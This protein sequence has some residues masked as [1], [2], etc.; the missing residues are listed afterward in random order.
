[1]SINF[2]NI[3]LDCINFIRNQTKFVLFFVTL[4]VI[5]TLILH[6]MMQRLKVQA[7]MTQGPSISFL[8]FSMA[9]QLITLVISL[10]LLHTVIMISQHQKA[11][12]SQTLIV[13]L[14]K[15]PLFLLLNIISVIPFALAVA[16]TL[17]SGGKASILGITALFVGGYMFLRFCLAPYAYA[18]DNYKFN[19]SLQFSW[20]NANGRMFTLFL[21]VLITF[22]TPSLI[23]FKL[24]QWNSGLIS[25]IIF[26]SVN[27]FINV[28]VLI[29]TYR[30]YQLFIDRNRLRTNSL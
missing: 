17:A 5:D 10:W 23:S 14:K 27:G 1:M 4:L 19:Q 2:A 3:T 20:A 28:F 11:D 22:I 13:S 8:L 18:I 21:F 26:A 16:S 9:G 12:L 24:S 30:F 7:D 6:Q 15:L 29:Y 25:D